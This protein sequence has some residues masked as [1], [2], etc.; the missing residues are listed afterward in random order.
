MSN[1]FWCALCRNT[2]LF[3][4]ILWLAGCA[5]DERQ[6][7]ED[8]INI[9]ASFYPIYEFART[10]GGEHVHVVNLIPAGVEPHEW[11]P[12][13][14]DLI[15]ASKAHLFMYNGAGLEGWVPDFLAS[16]PEDRKPVVVEV[17]RGIELIRSDEFAHDR[18]EA[19]NGHEHAH[20]A[21]IDPHTWVSPRSAIRMA[22][23][24]KNSLVESDPAH[25]ADYEANYAALH[26]QLQELDEQFR[27]VLGTVA[28]KEIVVSHQSFGY[29][30]RDYGLK[31]V[32]IMGLSP[33]AE[34]RSQDLKRIVDFVKEHGVRYIFFEQLV[35][36]QLSK[37]L[38]EEAGVGVLPLHP[39]EGLT[40]EQERNGDNY[41]TIMQ[42]NLQNLRKALE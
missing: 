5:A 34:P 39:V 25:A 41:I 16:L 42:M 12:R 27:Q 40:R 31:Q 22:E 18:D 24:I 20:D 35:S 7:S 19:E 26:K 3:F 21:S 17:S 36:D 2:A 4:V 37:T 30:A 8:K 11:S 13:S 9:V 38:A 32:A 10:I 15:H 28:R 14:R 1:R 33:D 23:T 6:L 29:L